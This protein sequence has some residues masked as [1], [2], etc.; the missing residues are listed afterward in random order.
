MNRRDLAVWIIVLI[1]VVGGLIWWIFSVRPTD[2]AVA[3]AVR[4]LESLPSAEMLVSNEL[5]NELQK[6]DPHGILPVSPVPANPPRT[7][8]FQP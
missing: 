6:R 1:A 7:D 8:P 4:P 5:I 2:E 3:A